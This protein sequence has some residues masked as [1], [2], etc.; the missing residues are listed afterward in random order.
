MSQDLRE[1][2]QR[3]SQLNDADKA[4]LLFFLLESLESTDRDNIEE[5]WRIE[6]EARLE[7][8]GRG[9]AITVPAQEV[10]TNLDRR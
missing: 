7:A 4:H 8:V 10:F 1:L 6:A 2:E 3:I 9:D 5:A